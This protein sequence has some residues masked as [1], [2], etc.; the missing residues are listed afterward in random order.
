[1]SSFISVTFASFKKSFQ[2]NSFSSFFKE[3][4]DVVVFSLTLEGRLL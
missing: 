1:M 2:K 3:A 4:L